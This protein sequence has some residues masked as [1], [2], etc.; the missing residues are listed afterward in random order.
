M[1][2]I[3]FVPVVWAQN[4]ITFEVREE[5]TK[6]PIVG[7]KVKIKGSEDVALTDETGKATL[8]PTLIGSHSFLIEAEGFDAQE[9]TIKF[10]LTQNEIVL[11]EV[12]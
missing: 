4:N 1:L 12:V 7:A 5:S 10:P 6:S 3:F 2:A 11:I 8:T 9:T